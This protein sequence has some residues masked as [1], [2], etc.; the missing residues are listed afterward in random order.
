VI[1]AL[2]AMTLWP[3][4]QHYEEDRKGSLE[5]GKVADLVILSRDPTQGDLDTI[6]EILVMET[7]K[8]GQTVFALTGEEKQQAHQLNR[9]G[10]RGDSAFSQFVRKASHYAHATPGC[11]DHTC[12]EHAVLHA[13]SCGC[14]FIAE[15]AGLIAGTSRHIK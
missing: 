13:S 12:E 8:E 10:G 15:L 14:A 2:K 11:D 7:I 5:V 6:D 9:P 4:W 3:A 1:T